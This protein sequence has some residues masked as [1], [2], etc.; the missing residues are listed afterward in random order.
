M[1]KW[2]WCAK[3]SVSATLA[4]ACGLLFGFYTEGLWPGH[5]EW[6]GGFTMGTGLYF[7][8]EQFGLRKF[9]GS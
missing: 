9:R 2:E 4:V 8:S 7:W 3:W 6:M 5:G 1:N